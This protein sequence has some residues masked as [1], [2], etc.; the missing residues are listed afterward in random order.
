M[1]AHWD[2]EMT[3]KWNLKTKHIWTYSNPKM[4]NWTGKNAVLFKLRQNC[5]SR[6]RFY[7]LSIDIIAKW[8]FSLVVI[9]V[10]VDAVRWSEVDGLPFR[11]L[12]SS[13]EAATRD[14]PFFWVWAKRNQQL[15]ALLY[16][17][18]LWESREG[19]IKHQSSQNSLT[20]WVPDAA[21]IGVLAEK[22]D[23][24]VIMNGG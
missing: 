8:R 22:G 9:M 1:R 2:E 18:I 13:S 23:G 24:I 17:S 10:E 6:G 3:H 12:V 4:Q 19:S 5:W 21:L 15:W 16:P 11:S 14:M 20:H 7:I